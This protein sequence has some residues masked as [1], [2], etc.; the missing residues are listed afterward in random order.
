MQNAETIIH[1][2]HSNL[3]RDQKF[4]IKKIFSNE[5]ITPEEGLSLYDWSNLNLLGTLANWKRESLHG[6]RTYFIQNQHLNNT[7]ICV[8]HC[9]FCSFRR[10]Q[11]EEGSYSYTKEEI[12]GRIER[13]K[14]TGI[15][16]VHIVNGLHPHL[17]I[18][19]YE[20]VLRGIK[21][22]RPDLHIKAFTAVEIDFFAKRDHL[23]ISEV[24]QRL[25]N[26]GLDSLPGGGAEIF[27]SKTRQE[28][29]GEKID[30][31]RWLEIHEMAHRMGIHSTCTMLY[32]HIE[33]F[34]DR[35]QHMDN[36]RNLQDKTDGFTCFI[37]LRCRMSIWLLMF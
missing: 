34:E 33:T 12:Y 9:K 22:I 17:K 31:K 37:P 1:L 32:G 20:E 18:D 3:T 14:G 15:R 36:L 24:L 19:F 5:R 6:N 2:H 30:T 13:T 26:A 8:L 23:S 21:K 28:I 16:E 11:N 27:S 29:C 25:K 7:N 10:S 4:I 35:I